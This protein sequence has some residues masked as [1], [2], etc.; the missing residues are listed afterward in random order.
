MFQ[1]NK[2]IT[3]YRIEMNFFPFSLY[4]F[5]I[6]QVHFIKYFSIDGAPSSAPNSAQSDSALEAHKI[7]SKNYSSTTYNFREKDEREV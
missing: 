6:F 3:E 2:Y 1:Q 7:C 4:R 5:S